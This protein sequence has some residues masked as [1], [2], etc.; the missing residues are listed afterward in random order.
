MQSTKAGRKGGAQMRGLNSR[1]EVCSGANRRDSPLN[2]YKG[3]DE[4]LGG[5]VGA[6]VD[7][8]DGV[9][10]GLLARDLWRTRA[11]DTLELNTSQPMWFLFRDLKGAG[12]CEQGLNTTQ[13]NQNRLL[14]R[15]LRRRRV[16]DKLELKATRS[17]PRSCNRT[18]SAWPLLLRLRVARVEARGV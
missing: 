8:M 5:E 17:L 3:D 2:I 4:A 15:D 1:R 10:N 14:A 16:R 9:K 6:L 13:R 11:R 18:C 7:R 12:E